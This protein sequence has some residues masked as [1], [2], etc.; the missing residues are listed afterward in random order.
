MKILIIRFSSI[1]D[2]VL[3]T[4]VVRGLKEQLYGSEV[5]YCTKASFHQVLEANP[6][7]SK[8]HFLEDSLFKLI[9]ELKA[10]KY[11]LVIDLHNNLRTRIIK[12]F[13]G[14][15]SKTF[16]KLNW[17]KWQMVNLKKNKLPKV[18]IVDRYFATVERLAV[19]YDG[20]GLDYFIPANDEIQLKSLPKQ[21]QPGYYV[22][23]IG[24][25]H[26]TKK[27]P[28]NKMKELV[29]KINVPLIL[30]GGKEDSLNGTELEKY[31][32]SIGKQILNLC[33]KTSLNQSASYVKQS[34]KVFT[35]DT[36]LMH[37]AAAFR[38]EVISIWGNTIPEFGMYPF[39][40]KHTILE[41][42]GLSCRPC[43]KIGYDKCP[44]GHFKCM[45]LQEFVEPA[46]L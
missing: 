16:E 2:I 8:F 34:G 31:G 1:G 30:L 27:L 22:Y 26:E 19:S 15:P 13:L 37:I 23:A 43:S 7:I 29:S 14:I 11:D 12:M 38:K 33:G 36:G 32:K 46:T 45:N 24:G 4:P 18:H 44:R 3:T 42:K 41:V 35:H 39:Q 17:E 5:H 28:L 21:F 40:T 10:E 6:Y 25:Q 20:R 9:S